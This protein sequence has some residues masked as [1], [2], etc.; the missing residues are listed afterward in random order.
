MG[1]PCSAFDWQKLEYV[2]YVCPGTSSPGGWNTSGPG[3]KVPESSDPIGKDI[4]ELLP[5]LGAGCKVVGRGTAAI[6]QIVRAP[7][8]MGSLGADDVPAAPAP[9]WTK[10]PVGKVAIGAV[11]GFVLYRVLKKRRRAR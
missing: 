3:P 9:S 1:R 8:M 10:I 5:P 2:Y 11:I 7:R 6:G 4:E